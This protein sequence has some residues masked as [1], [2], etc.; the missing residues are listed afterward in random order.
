MSAWAAELAAGRCPAEIEAQLYKIL[1]KPDKNAPEY[2]AVVEAAR[3][4][5][6][7]PLEL[8]KNTGAIASAYQFH[9]QRFLFEHFPK[10]TQFPPQALAAALASANDLPLAGVQAYSIDDSQ[11][12]EIDDAL[13]VEGLGSGQV[14]LGIHIAAPALAI[15]PG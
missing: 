2:K 8:L 4:T 5:Q 13:S 11:T 15:T 7:A 10:G 6:L 1:F 12:T 3:A 14:T 9:W